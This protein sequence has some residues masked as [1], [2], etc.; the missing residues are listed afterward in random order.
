MRAKSE[1][2]EIQSSIETQKPA[3]EQAVLPETFL[4][5][6]GQPEAVIVIGK[7]RPPF[8]RWVAD[9]VQR[10][11]LRLSGAELPIVTEDNIPAQGALLLIGGPEA[12]S[13]TAA[14]MQTVP[15]DFIGLKENGFFLKTAVV[16]GRPALLI[17]GR[18]EAGTMY[19][20]YDFVE[21]LGVVFQTTGDIIPQ[22]K[23]DLVLPALNVRQEPALRYRGHHL[24]QFVMPWMGV[25]YLSRYLDQLAKL[26]YNYLEFFWYEGAPWVEYAYRGEKRLIGDIYH[27]ESGYT[28]WRMETYDFSASD[29][30]IGRELFSHERPCAPEFQQC[31]TPEEAHLIA[32]A[33]LKE[34]IAHAHR[35]KIGVWLGAG[36]CPFV[37]PNLGRFSGRRPGIFGTHMLDGVD[38]WTEIL[39]ATI[40]TYPEADGY[41]LWVAESYLSLSWLNLSEIKTMLKAGEKYR[42]LIPSRDAICK[43]GYDQYISHLGEEQI[44]ADALV[45]LHLAKTVIEN[46]RRLF[47]KVRLGVSLLGRS[48][49]FP[50]LHAALPKDVALQSM[51]SAICWN[52]NSRVPMENFAAGQGR[53]MFIVPRLDDDENELAAQFNVTLYEHDRLAPAP[54]FGVTGVVPQVGKTRGLEQN[55]RFLAESAWDPSLTRDRFYPAYAERIF[56]NKAKDGMLKAY[57]ILEETDM[58]L[59]LE[60]PLEKAGHCFC[61]IVNFVNYADNR[62]INE[63]KTFRQVHPAEGPKLFRNWDVTEEGDSE[64]IRRCRFRLNRFLEAIGRYETCRQLLQHARLEILAGAGHELEYL[65]YKTDCFILHLKTLCAL[66]QGH[67]AYDAAFCA[68]RKMNRE[69]ALARF[70][71]CAGHYRRTVVL[72]MDT[73]ARMATGID[74]PTERHILFRYNVRFLLPIREFY[75]FIRNVVNYH[76][77]QPYWELVNWDVIDPALRY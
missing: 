67:L 29:V 40:K 31:E 25:D 5:R 26:K 66:M 43:M 58:F 27:K 1:K 53:D 54:S 16:D 57:R 13:M 8:Y 75:K 3:A 44:T 38:I 22:A 7:N 15:L 24:R 63:L 4:V 10:Y 9:E 76:K 69:E 65:I 49:L 73:T 28:A 47:P 36:D 61:G 14:A 55:A 46:V 52:H 6:R 51:E 19:A 34:T 50:A 12:N 18:D 77:G 39:I 41:W 56:G 42:P 37:P 20:A 33:Y 68:L 21:R 59:G 62:D 74:D 23:P 45:Q 48:Y 72:V 17:A 71:E 11:L 35:R 60:V 30:V 70:E 32:Q 64:Y 2:K